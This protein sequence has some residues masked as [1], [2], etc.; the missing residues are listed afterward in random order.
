VIGLA[1]IEN[2]GRYGRVSVTRD[3]RGRFVH[4]ELYVEAL[5]RKTY[6]GKSI[7]IYGIGVNRF[8][9]KSRRYEFFG[10]GRE[11]EQ[12]VRRAIHLPPKDRFVSV[13]AREFLDNPYKYGSEGYWD[14]VK[15]DS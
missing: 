1:K 8:G 3:E 14:D 13:S 10:V 15:V 12:A 11:L 2:W 7:A 6:Y 4:W 5:I 9:R